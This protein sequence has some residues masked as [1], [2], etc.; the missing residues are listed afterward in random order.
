M[1]SYHY[2]E[3]KVKSKKNIRIL[4]HHTDDILIR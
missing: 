1:L 4:F 3:N 2:N